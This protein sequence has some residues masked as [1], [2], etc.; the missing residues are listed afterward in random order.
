MSQ[1]TTVYQ[2]LPRPNTDL[3]TQHY[4]VSLIDFTISVNFEVFPLSHSSMV[5][6]L[7]SDTVCSAMKQT[8]RDA[9]I[10][11]QQLRS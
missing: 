10:N 6:S 2:L 9:Y 1:R 8:I 5:I 3:T 7:G 4:Y 11:N